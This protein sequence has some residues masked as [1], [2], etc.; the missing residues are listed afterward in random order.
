MDEENTTIDSSG[1]SPENV[2]TGDI[3][4]N[5]EHESRS[6][7]QMVGQLIGQLAAAGIDVRHVETDGSTW[8]LE[9]DND[10]A[11]RGCWL[12]LSAR[13]SISGDRLTCA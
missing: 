6:P 8:R 10:T 13:C 9:T 12:S 3:P 4:V 1:Q 11:M 5:R 2:T 7:E